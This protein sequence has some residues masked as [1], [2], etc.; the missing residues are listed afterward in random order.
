MLGNHS[1]EASVIGELVPSREFYDYADKYVDEGARIIIPAQLAPETA[2]AM[3]DLAVRAYRA[4]DCT[5]LARVDF[6][7]SRNNRI[8]VNEINT[9]PGFTAISV[10][11]KL[12]EASGLK[13]SDLID[14]LISLALERHADKGKLRTKY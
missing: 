1:P 11:P 6:F 8:L 3:R 10:Y 7:L 5:G 12:W 9:L 2:A 4:I 14:R 13:S